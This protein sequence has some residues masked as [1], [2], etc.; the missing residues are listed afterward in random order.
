[1]LSGCS[2][3]EQKN[4]PLAK[5]ILEQF[6]EY[7]HEDTERIVFRKS[8]QPE[9]FLARGW[10]A[11]EEKYTWAD[12][13][14]S[15]IVFY[16]YDS[17]H[18]LAMELTCKAMPAQNNQQQHTRLLLNGDEIDSFLLQPDEFRTFQVTL[19]AS[20]LLSGQNILEF[21]YSY[22]TRPADLYANHPDYRTLAAA[23]TRILFHNNDK[24][25]KEIRVSAQIIDFSQEASPEPYL[26][27]GWSYPE[28]RHTWAAAKESRLVFHSYGAESDVKL[29]IT[30]QAIPAVDRQPQLTTVMLNGKAIGSFTA[31]PDEFRTYSVTLPVELLYAGRNELTFRFTYTTKPVQLNP[32]VPDGR[33]LAVDFQK[34]EFAYDSG[35]D[36]NISGGLFQRAETSLSLLIPLPERFELEVQYRSLHGTQAFIEFVNEQQEIAAN[37][38]LSKKKQYHKNIVEFKERGLYKLR[39]I[40]SGQPEGYTLWSQIQLNVPQEL[41]PSRAGSQAQ[42]APGFSKQDKPDILLYVVDTL[43]ADHLSCYGYP[44]LTTPNIDR[45]AQENA[46]F[47]NAYTVSSWTRA[48]GSSILTGLFPKNNKTMLRDDKLPEEMVTLAEILQEQGYYT[49]AFVTNWNVGRVFGFAQGFEEFHELP[50]DDPVAK[51]TQSDTLNT[52]VFK[53][54]DAFVQRPQRKPLFLMIWSMDPHD[55][56]TPHE[57][58]KHLFDIE[59]HTPLE[60]Y[61]FQLVTKLRDREIRPTQSQLE[62]LKTR[63]DQEITFNDRSFGNLLD[64]LKH[65]NVYDESVIVLTADHGEEFFEHGGY[66]HGRT[67]YN[68]QVAI[69]LI[70]KAPLLKQGEHEERAQLIDLYPTLIALLG[71]STPYPLDGVSLLGASDSTR[72]LYFEQVHDENDLNAL[73][74]AKKKVIYTLNVNRRPSGNDVPLTEIF[75]VTDKQEI[76]ELGI[77]NRSDAFRLQRLLTIRR[78]KSR[79]DFQRVRIDISPELDRKLKDLGYVK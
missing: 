34:I 74:D 63:Y 10:A 40:T 73:L 41:E 56:Y 42:A 9:E 22:T 78:K 33:D 51:S 44:R 65:L 3:K 43:R 37:I 13:K 31:V 70:V 25:E 18:D 14:V 29:Q 67:L 7:L 28:Q 35:A 75:D 32:Q 6:Q 11:P 36:E 12:E 5:D 48:S 77:R 49:A 58:V 30:C 17:T 53:F 71:L 64:K 62:Y 15:S 69:P 23:F 20:K 27:E 52:H 16:Q 57:S 45:F 72:T 55:P 26:G 19:P 60:T 68:D 66:G 54:L 39:L 79:L 50:D 59:Q 2:G 38:P 46:L 4:V 24:L 76:H 21:H 1:A 47:K 61:D 8:R